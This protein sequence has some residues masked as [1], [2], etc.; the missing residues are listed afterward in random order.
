MKR[1]VDP[2]ELKVVL[3]RLGVERQIRRE[4]ITESLRKD[5]IRP[6]DSTNPPVLDD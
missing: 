1:T 3:L 5:L 6:L 4:I 2:N